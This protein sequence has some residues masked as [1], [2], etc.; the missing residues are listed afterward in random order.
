MTKADAGLRRAGFRC[1]VVSLCLVEP[2]LADEVLLAQLPVTFELGL[3]YRQLR[4]RG[5][6]RLRRFTVVDAQQHIAL[7]HRS[8]GINTNVNAAAGHL[9]RVRG[10]LHRLD[11]RFGVDA[12]GD[13]LRREYA[14]RQ[15]VRKCAAQH[16]KRNDG[17]GK[18]AHHI[19]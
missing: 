5:L 6:C 16:A 8:A 15:R 4:L 11:R 3:R 13:R 1:I 14:R 2:S 17:E 18:Y 10:L 19:Y 7:R 12:Q 9:R